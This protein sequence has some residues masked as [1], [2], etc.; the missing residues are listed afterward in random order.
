MSRNVLC[1]ITA[2][3]GAAAGVLIAVLVRWLLD[4]YLGDQES[5][6]TFYPV[7]AMVAWYWGAGPSIWAAI[8]SGL[9]GHWYFLA[10]RRIITLTELEPQAIANLTV[11]VFTSLA[12]AAFA[13]AMRLARSRA[14]AH[15]Q[16]VREHE[17]RLAVEEQERR[18]A[19]AE[20]AKSVERFQLVGK[21][22]NDSIWDLNV[23]TGELWWSERILVKPVEPEVLEKLLKSLELPARAG[24]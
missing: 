5:F 9:A 23:A 1:R 2:Y 18:E 13:H 3:G 16:E 19:Q 22:T 10:P 14:D 6:A 12:V 4:P 17:R 20:L 21:A 8:L 15:A 7:V 24:N 11:F